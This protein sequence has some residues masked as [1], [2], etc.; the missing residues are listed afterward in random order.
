MTVVETGNFAF[1]FF[2]TCITKYL[3]VILGIVFF[4]AQHKARLVLVFKGCSRRT[5][6]TRMHH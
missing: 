6:A 1:D 3:Q 2:I 5:K 4:G